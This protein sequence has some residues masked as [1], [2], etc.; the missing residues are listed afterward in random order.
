M[1]VGPRVQVKPIEGDALRT[2][3]DHGHPWAHLP[4]EAVLVHA[5]VPRR[6]PQPEEFWQKKGAIPVYPVC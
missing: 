5:E 2:N 4:V 1:L 3:G 6:I